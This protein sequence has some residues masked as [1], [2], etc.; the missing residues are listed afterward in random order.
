MA[1]NMIRRQSL[2]SSTFTY[3]GFA[4]GAVNILVLFPRYFSPEQFGLTRILLD[5]AMLLSTICTL[6]SIPIVLKFFPLYKKNTPD[7]RN[8]LPWLSIGLVTLGCLVTLLILPWMKP[9]IIRKFGSKS[10]LFVDYFDLLYPFTITLAYFS[11]FEAYAWSLRKTILSNILKE[12]A[13]RLLT[14]I[15]IFLFIAGIVKY[16]Q[17][18]ALYAWIFL[19]PVII[20]LLMI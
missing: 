8:D 12:F 4:I 10:P 18:I 19:L 14:T 2:V 13:F 7:G 16:N 20:F 1:N 6:G 11:L 3:L 15:L 5:V 9:W 17:F